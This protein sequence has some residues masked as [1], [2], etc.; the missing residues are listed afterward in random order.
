MQGMQ[1]MQAAWG[2]AGET[3]MQIFNYIKSFLN[4]NLMSQN[5]LFIYRIRCRV[6]EKANGGTV[7]TRKDS[8]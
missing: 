8:T 5:K 6:I 4:N 2:S 1:G 3:N 7:L